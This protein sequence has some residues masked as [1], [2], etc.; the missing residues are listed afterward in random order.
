VAQALQNMAFLAMHNAD[1]DRARSYF[2]M[3]SAVLQ[4]AGL[5]LHS[6]QRIFS[7]LV[8][9]LVSVSLLRS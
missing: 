5:P 9:V 4:S 2:S 3:S 6:G 8:R 7:F 1:L